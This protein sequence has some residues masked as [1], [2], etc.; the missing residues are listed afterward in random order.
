[1][2]FKLL[3]FCLGSDVKLF[4]CHFSKITAF[5]HAVKVEAKFFFRLLSSPFFQG[6]KLKAALNTNYLK[7]GS[8][9]AFKLF[10]FLGSSWRHQA[11]FAVTLFY[12]N[13]NQRSIW[14]RDNRNR[15]GNF[16][17]IV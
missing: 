17:T 8:T 12:F 2:A 3:V 5:S 10:S 7:A 9:L 14:E 1:M 13:Q 6:R 16:P 15:W 11:R 4:A